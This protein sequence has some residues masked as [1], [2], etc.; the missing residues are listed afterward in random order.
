MLIGT[1]KFVASSNGPV[2]FIEPPIRVDPQAVVGWA[3]VP[4]PCH[5]YDHSY[6]Q[7]V[8]GMAARLQRASAASP[9]RSTS[10]T[11][12]ARARC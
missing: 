12:A 1:G 8:M 11:S 7:G 9:A 5:H 6:M 3:D 10:S 2:H 4:S